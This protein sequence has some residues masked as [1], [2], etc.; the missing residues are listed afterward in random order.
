[1]RT[2]VVFVAILSFLALLGAGGCAPRPAAA[3]QPAVASVA[4]APRD[5]ARPEL[6]VDTAWLVRHR[7][8]PKVR[9]IDVRP[10]DKY[11]EGHIPGAVN[12]PPEVFAVK[13]GALSNEL[14]P[15]DRFADTMGALGVGPDTHV[16]IYDDGNALWA[17]RLFFTLD[18]Y[19]HRRISILNGGFSAWSAEGR[20]VSRV[21]P[22]VPRATFTPRFDRSKVATLADVQESLQ[23]GGVVFCDARSPAEYRGEDVRSKRGGR[24]P[25]ARNVDWQTTVGKVNGVPSFRSGADLARLYRE[26]GL[27]PDQ[28]VITYCQTGVRAAHAYFTLR[29]LGYQKVRNYDGSWEEWG[30]LPDTP[31]ER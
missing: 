10:A 22:T 9:I 4:P 7:N 28:E 1:M 17:A 13:V 3:P 8:D 16:V 30:N 15:P 11:R 31:V 2:L 29:L 24:V 21:A 23:K 25:G 19:G 27:R 5:V 6:L 18:V 26:A 12:L 14:P 20:E